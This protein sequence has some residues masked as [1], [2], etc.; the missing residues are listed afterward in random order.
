MLKNQY[1]VN[2]SLNFYI[3]LGPR[4]SGIASSEVTLKNE[5]GSEVIVSDLLNFFFDFFPDFVAFPFPGWPL[6]ALSLSLFF[7]SINAA[8]FRVLE[9]KN[10]T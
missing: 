7:M 2:L 8:L 5:S 9:I 10:R 1:S 4:K 3:G 6:M